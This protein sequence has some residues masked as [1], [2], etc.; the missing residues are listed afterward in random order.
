[1]TFESPAWLLLLPAL[2]LAAWFWR[3]LTLWRPLRA[4]PLILIVAMLA[5]PRAQLQQDGM[6]LWVLLD[7]SESTEDRIDRGLPEWKK[8]M[9]EGRR[10]RDDELHLADYAMHTVLHEN[11]GGGAF[12]GSRKLTC[13]ALAIDSIIALRNPD[14]ASRL[15]LFTDGYSTEALT[16]I[17]DRLA[18]ENMPLDLRLLPEPPGNDYRVRRLRMPVRAQT[19]EPFLIEAEITGPGDGELPLTILRNGT[20]IMETK[21]VLT[22]GR[23][24]ARFTDRIGASGACKYEA[25]ISPPDDA[26][27]GNNHSEAWIEITGGP[28]LLLVTGYTNDPLAEVLRRQ[29]VLETVENA[30]TLQSGQLSGCRGVIFNN[31]PAWEVPADFLASLDFFVRAQGGGLLMAGGKRSFGAGG[32]FRSPVDELLPVSMELKKDQRKLV[33][34]IAIVLDRSGSMTAG[35]G[36]GR[37]KMDLANEGSAKAIEFMGHQDNVAV[38]AV[39]SEAHEMVPM[40]TI[41]DDDNKNDLMDLARR[42][43]SGGGGIFVFNGLKAG[44]KALRGTGT[45]T[46]HIILFADAADAEQPGDGPGDDYKSLLEEVVNDGATCSVIAL[47][48]ESD[49]DAAFLKDVAARGKGRIF[50]TD[51]PE[52]L[53]NIFTAE[54][55]AVTR[56][57]FISDPVATL[58]SGQWHEIS[59]KPLS[60]LPQVDGYN[61]SYKRDWASQALVTRDEYTAPLV[62]WGQRGA[63]RAAAVCFPLGGEFSEAVRAWPAYGDFLQ[64]AG[65]WLMGEDVPPDIGLR[66]DMAGTVLGIDLMYAGNWEQTFAQA[67]PRIL[68]ASGERAGGSREAT[69]ERMQPGHYRAAIDLAE[70]ELV[71]GAIIVGKHTLPF[72][73]LSAGSNAEWAFDPARVDELRQ[74]AAQSGGR[75]RVDLRDVWQSPPL[76]Q[77]TDLRRWLLPLALVLILADALISRM[78]WRLPKLALARPVRERRHVPSPPAIPAP[79]SVAEEPASEV[80][81]PAVPAEDTSAARRRRRFARAKKR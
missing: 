31:V 20:S 33:A 74:V 14:K 37:T 4:A 21:A 49:V 53:P 34:S 64:T 13:T 26:H 77:L 32:F 25:R 55:V 73:P 45:G 71:R 10:S 3:G 44:W 52:D 79:A 35:V 68:L 30:H 72:G 2:A 67:P 66:W 23:G 81:A 38:F 61:L 8:L 65:R 42:I 6:D 47:G 63:G 80:P 76:K 54:T 60:W 15:L 9:E 22:K 56:N 18:R 12:T 19:G 50:F 24:V 51:R 78:G 7:R 58:V 57:A 28:R 5:R 70:G 41:G 27:P 39:D 46:R 17:A 16:G 36:G 1:M 48:Q 59:A 62:A 43:T 75:E 69:W 11:S 40:Q 29:F